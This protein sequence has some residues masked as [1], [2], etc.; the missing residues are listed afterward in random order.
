MLKQS[1]ISI[2]EA[3]AY[4]E[5]LAEVSSIAFVQAVNFLGVVFI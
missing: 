1:N 5:K 2:M 4:T 3:T